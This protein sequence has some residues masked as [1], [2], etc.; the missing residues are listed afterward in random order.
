MARRWIGWRR[1]GM[2]STGR[3]EREPRSSIR[4]LPR[5]ASVTPLQL[6]PHAPPLPLSGR[7]RPPPCRVVLNERDVLRAF[8]VFGDELMR[9]VGDLPPGNEPGGYGEMPNK[10]RPAAP[11]L[12]ATRGPSRST[13]LHPA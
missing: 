5:T 10:E 9:D 1:W 8:P 13:E 12:E 2:G 4:P 6:T 3:G 7:I 11:K